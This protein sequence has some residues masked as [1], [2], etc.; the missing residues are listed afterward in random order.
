MDLAIDFLNGLRADLMDHELIDLMIEAGTYYF[1]YAIETG[2]PLA[3]A[4]TDSGPR[5]SW[6][7]PSIRN[8][9]S[10][11]VVTTRAERSPAPWTSMVTP[12]SGELD[13]FVRPKDLE[14]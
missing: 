11:S 14:G 6:S 2:R 8:R 3:T 4:H 7:G 12:G 9:P 13:A 1:A 10:A 5:R